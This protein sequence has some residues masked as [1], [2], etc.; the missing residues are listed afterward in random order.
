MKICRG[1]ALCYAA[2]GEQSSSFSHG[3][4]YTF[5]YEPPTPVNPSALPKIL[6]K[7]K[8]NK[9]EGTKGLT[10]PVTILLRDHLVEARRGLHS[11]HYFYNGEGGETLEVGLQ[12]QKTR[13]TRREHRGMRSLR[14]RNR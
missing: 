11:C 10:A 8:T 13:T 5:E 1:R 14:D 3:K 6:E 2:G 12:T 7:E 9:R 4:T